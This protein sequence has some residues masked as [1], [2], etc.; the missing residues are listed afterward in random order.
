MPVILSHRMRP[1]LWSDL[2]I[3]YFQ[4]LFHIMFHSEFAA[5][6]VFLEQ[7]LDHNNRCHHPLV[8][9]EIVEAAESMMYPC[10]IME[11]P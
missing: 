9:K 4:D 7:I 10:A 6:G 2:L 8:A 11:Q 1:T 5:A 3:H